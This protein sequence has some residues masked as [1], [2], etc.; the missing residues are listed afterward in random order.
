MTHGKKSADPALGARG[1]QF[2]SARPDYYNQRLTANEVFQFVFSF[3]VI[4][5]H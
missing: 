4:Y 5:M 1:R 2:K 3:L